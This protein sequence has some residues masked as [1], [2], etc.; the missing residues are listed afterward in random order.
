MED[1][2]IVEL[3][4]AR[5]EAAIAETA[6]KYGHY[7]RTIAYNVLSNSEDADEV[8]ND[9]Y[10]NAWD[11]MPPHRPN[12]LSTF[13]GKITRRL[14]IDALRSKLALKR[15]GSEAQISLEELGECFSSGRSIEETVE[16]RELSK[17][18][19]GFL[20]RLPE[21]ERDVFV[22]RYWFLSSV[23]D[24]AKRFETNEGRI[25][26]MLYRTRKKLHDYLRE[27]GY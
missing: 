14:S 13:L 5:A 27:E 24:I 8:V 1:S 10:L 2:S 20:S 7:C 15:G 16:L 22:C 18:V 23:R 12:I 21:Q 17:A 4:W 11:S 26:T 3:Y 25:K 9:T 6:K 19:N